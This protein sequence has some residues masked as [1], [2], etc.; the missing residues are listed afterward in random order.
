MAYKDPAMRREGKRLNRLGLSGAGLAKRTWKARYKGAC[1]TCHKSAAPGR[2][3]C[4]LCDLIAENK[5]T[6]EA[7][8][9]R[10]ASCTGQ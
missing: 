2:D 9:K 7:I 5:A 3:T 10:E 6:R 1:L 8:L 4:V